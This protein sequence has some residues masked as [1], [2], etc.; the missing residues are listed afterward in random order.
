MTVWLQQPCPW[1]ALSDITATSVSPTERD[2]SD[3]C[4]IDRWFLQSIYK[5]FDFTLSLCVYVCAC[6]C[7]CT[8]FQCPSSI[9]IAA[10]SCPRSIINGKSNRFC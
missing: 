4:G 8:L 7:T 2:I 10:D 9:P 6:V 3:L 1:A 5:H